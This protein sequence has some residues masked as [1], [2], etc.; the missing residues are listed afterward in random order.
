MKD[1]VVMCPLESIYK[2]AQK[3]VQEHAYHNVDVV[4]G[5]MSNGV[6]LAGP[7]I[8]QGAKIMVSRGGTYRLLRA[9]YSIPVTEIKVDAYDIVQSYER[10][11]SKVQRIG[12]VGYSNII[13]GFG[14]LKRIIPQ[15]VRMIELKREQGVYEII[16]QNKRE[17]ITTFIGDANIIPIVKQ[18]GCDGFVI[19]SR[20]E[21]ILAA[22]QEGRRILRATRQE[23][24]RTQ[25]LLTMTDFIHD[26][27]I[28]VDTQERITIFNKRAKKIFNVEDTDIIGK[29]IT[30]V[31]P[32]SQLPKTLQ[33]KQPE[34]AQLQQIN[35]AAIS[36][37]RLPIIAEGELLGAVATFQRVDDLQKTEQK[38]RQEL[39]QKGFVAKY[40][41]DD[42]VHTSA[43]ISA[44][45]AMAKKYAAY[46]TPVHICGSSGVGK[47]LFC[48]SIHNASPRCEGPF[49]A[50]NCAAIAPS[51][52]E[53][54]LFGYTEGAFT[55]ASRKGRAGIFELAHGGTLFL[56]EISEIP[57]DL[58]GR[59]LRVLQEKQVLRIGGSK[60]V[61]IN[62][63]VIT[64]SNRYLGK[65]IEN[66][67][68]RQDL[69]FRIN[70]LTLRIP[71]LSRRKQDILPLA[72]LFV[73]R[74]CKQ[75]GK[76]LMPIG[77]QVQAAL[78]A[79]HYPGNVREL[80]GLMEKCV[81]LDS[82]DS[83][84]QGV[85]QGGC[86]PAGSHGV[87]AQAQQSA[88]QPSFAAGGSV[89]PQPGFTGAATQAPAIP[90]PPP[91]LAGIG[92]GELTT[93][94]SA[95]AHLIH[96]ALQASNGSISKAAVALG[97]SRS[98][99]WRKMKAMGITAKPAAHP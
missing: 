95:E 47:E 62:V 63:R 35:G 55:G 94:H 73:A 9:A 64:A 91:A 54:E 31:L 24:A 88:G 21:N 42:I 60:M 72:K 48:Q 70:I 59:L 19:Q 46:D 44:C 85:G 22:I 68:F 5:N 43:E 28:A 30:Q 13:H 97:I 89:L 3:I 8:E 27:V 58:Q 40:T 34:V 1:I 86:A 50:I 99:L 53:S 18:L 74:Y 32:T 82:F 14:F 76:P 57:L 66:G 23:N 25:W 7:I 2:Q 81:I 93:L 79:Y 38:I 17:G 80:E 84:L 51:L 15:N 36:T 96:K 20:E 26:A 49:V 67:L 4:F 37:N 33:N 87:P 61:P 41:F 77:P 16:E 71:P 98:T 69:Y 12:V 6:Q 45:I 75:Y 56:D 52:I 39:A 65:M 90:A 11:N 29:K 10:I 83:L 92:Q 78:T